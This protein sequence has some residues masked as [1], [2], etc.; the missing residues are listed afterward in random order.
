MREHTG[1]RKTKRQGK[2]EWSREE[3][4]K[5][6]NGKNK[7]E[8]RKS[9]NIIYKMRTGKKDTRKTTVKLVLLYLVIVAGCFKPKL[10]RKFY[11]ILWICHFL[12]P[13]RSPAVV[14]LSA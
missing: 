4:R 3:N 8:Q 12:A 7:G 14:M 13:F 10:N 1:E 11:G 2:D 5:G 6:M 9:G